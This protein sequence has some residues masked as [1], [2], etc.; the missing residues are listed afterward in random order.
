MLT[1]QDLLRVGETD[2]DRID[3]VY[4][5]IREHK[6]SDLYT[7]AVI[8]NDYDKHKNRTILEFRKF[9][10]NILGEAVPD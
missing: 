3:F 5:A 4:R 8:A 10:K 9:V 7:T 2:N 6:S 1:Y